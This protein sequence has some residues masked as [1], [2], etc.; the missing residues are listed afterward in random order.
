MLLL[1][2]EQKKNKKQKNLLSLSLHA[3]LHFDMLDAAAVVAHLAG[4]CDY[5]HERCAQLA[6]KR[7]LK[8]RLPG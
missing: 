6:I 5:T 2:R 1:L 7:R 4:A 8:K 3:V